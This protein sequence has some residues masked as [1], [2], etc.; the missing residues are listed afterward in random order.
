LKNSIPAKFYWFVVTRFW[1]GDIQSC[2]QELVFWAQVVWGKVA[3][4]LL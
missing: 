3:C 4:L 2:H 1:R